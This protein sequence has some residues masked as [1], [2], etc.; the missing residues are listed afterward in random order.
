M[1]KFCSQCGAPREQQ[2]PF[3]TQCGAAFT[4]PSTPP[5]AAAVSP[6]PTPI[7]ASVAGSGTTAPADPPTPRPSDASVAADPTRRADPP[8]FAAAQPDDAS[9]VVGGVRRFGRAQAAQLGASLTALVAI[10]LPW[11]RSPAGSIDAT[12]VS[13]FVLMDYERGD[14]GFDLAVLVV[15]GAALSLA[16]LLLPTPK[17]RTLLVCG[18]VG[19]AIVGGLFLFQMNRLSQDVT[20]SFTRIVGIGP[21]LVLASS[22]VL[23]LIARRQPTSHAG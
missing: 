4:P 18:G 2:R 3:C 15:A 5:D 1:E 23:L 16:A 7:P 19:L 20:W 12:D 10:F 22:I 9:S 13:F 21:I 14:R 11:A 17:A 6:T 8:I